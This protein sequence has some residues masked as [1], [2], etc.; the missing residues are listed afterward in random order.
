MYS[1]NANIV[2][3]IYTDRA[4]RYDIVHHIITLWSDSKWRKK[5]SEAIP[6]RAGKIL[7]LC[8]GTGETIV[9]I[10]R[11]R[12]SKFIVGVDFTDKMLEKSVSKFSN[13]EFITFIQADVQ[14]LPF[15]SNTFDAV[16]SVCGLG[17][18]SRPDLAIRE[19]KRVLNENGVFFAVEMCT[20]PSR[21]LSKIWHKLAIEP[22][23]KKYWG[24]RDIQIEEFVKNSEFK[25][26]R[27]IYRMERMLGS[28]CEIIAIA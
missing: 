13:Y 25:S 9:E 26:Y 16:L 28:I 18:V 20:P 4:N 24:F 10:N 27:C 17:G 5:A 3:K 15:R 21:V 12:K 11:R 7:D 1:V 8:T 22:W 19:A 14:I 23:V 2:K 6:D